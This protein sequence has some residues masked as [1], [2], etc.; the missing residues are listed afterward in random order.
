MK[1]LRGE[2]SRQGET[3]AGVQRGFVKKTRFV[4]GSVISLFSQS[5]SPF[6]RP[7]CN[8][9]HVSANFTFPET[10]REEVR[11]GGDVVFSGR[12][13]YL[14]S[15]PFKSIWGHLKTA[16][17]QSLWCFNL[18]LKLLHSGFLRTYPVKS[19]NPDEKAL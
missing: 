13:S 12:C 6:S 15:C 4:Q 14:C 11:E 2:L 1:L 7:S 17:P 19:F 10:L 8:C 16:P 5:P 18:I 3:L 9:P